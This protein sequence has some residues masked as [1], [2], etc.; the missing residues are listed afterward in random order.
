MPPESE[1]PAVVYICAT[2]GAETT[3]RNIGAITCS[4]NP[5]HRVLY[6]KR[7]TRPQV[8]KCI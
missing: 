8:Y 1:P 3:P 7:T 6:K 2:C 5:Q 4:A